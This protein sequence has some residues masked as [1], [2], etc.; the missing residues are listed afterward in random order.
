MFTRRPDSQLDFY[1]AKCAE[2]PKDNPVF[3][4][5]YAHARTCS[6]KRKFAEAG[7]DAARAPDLSLLD[8]DEIV[9]VKLITQFPRVVEEA[10]THHEP[11]RIA[12]YLGDLAAD[13]HALWNRGH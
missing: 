8:E 1:S 9:L 5:Q 7:F 6:L 3:D 10:A 13:L 2:Q 11:H 4:V 12:F